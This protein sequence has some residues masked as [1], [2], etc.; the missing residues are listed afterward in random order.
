[1]FAKN[2]SVL[3]NRWPGLSGLLFY[4]DAE[5][6]SLSSAGVVTTLL[7][8]GI[9]L[10]SCY[11]AVAEARTQAQLIPQA[12]TEAWVYGV[13]IGEL[14]RVLFGRS[15]L[16]KITVVILNAELFKSV[17][18][19][20]DCTDWLLD[21]RCELL[22]GDSASVLHFPFCASPACLR[23]ANDRAASL[24]DHV[25]LALESA[26]INNR[27]RD[28]SV[29]AEQLWANEK[30]IQQDA[31]VS[32]LFDSHLGR[33]AVVLAAG[34]T[35][36]EYLGVIQS[37]QAQGKLLIAVDAALGVLMAQGIVPD[38]VVSID[39]HPEGVNTLFGG[40][41]L[42]CANVP[43]IYFPAVHAD[44]LSKWPGPRY[45]AF[46]SSP[47]YQELS[48][49][50]PNK[51]VLFASGSVL[52]SAVDLSVK[53]G[54]QRIHFFGADFCF[55]NGQSHADGVAHRQAVADTAV[56]DWV[57]NGDGE[58]VG[59]TRNL[60]GYLRDLESYIKTQPDRVFINVSRQGAKIDGTVFES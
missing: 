17:L 27:F 29:V 8:Q 43:L 60:R 32:T 15:E 48:A 50:Y 3:K 10:S 46:S 5:A 56:G 54:C 52:H 40:D 53:L 45:V 35:L 39:E 22:L 4:V 2:M 21:E 12:A 11:D 20:F 30:N 16:K 38:F 49:R 1:M 13:G 51:G 14:P 31:G 24:R 41:L 9:H 36:S 25:V 47:V 44:V 42:S 7:V 37:H 33:E 55:P 6:V 58:R 34:P 26:Y 23:L 57:L 18:H 19:H 28:N 59:T